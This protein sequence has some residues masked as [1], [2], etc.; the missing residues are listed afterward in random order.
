MG[1]EHVT[2]SHDKVR[3]FS[4]FTRF[5]GFINA[6]I[7]RRGTLPSPTPVD[8]TAT[9]AMTITPVAWNIVVELGRVGRG[10]VEVD[11]RLNRNPGTSLL[12]QPRRAS[13]LPLLRLFVCSLP[14]RA[15]FLSCSAHCLAFASACF[16][17]PR[18]EGEGALF[19]L[20]TTSPCSCCPSCR[21]DLMISPTKRT[22]S[23]T[24][25]LQSDHARR[26]EGSWTL[27]KSI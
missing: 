3:R 11:S 17:L 19:W 16:A 26:T 18:G 4:N 5:A 24:I 12:G 7:L 8:I 25:L 14:C 9:P 21:H 23:C 20:H 1:L 2:S 10:C 13:R 6:A 15:W 22:N 27:T